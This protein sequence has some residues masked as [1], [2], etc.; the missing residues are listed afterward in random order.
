MSEPACLGG[1]PQ[2]SPALPMACPQLPPIESVQPAFE[3][4]MA[5]GYMTKGPELAAFEE[6]CQDYL[7]VEHCMGVSSCTSG[8]MMT[9]QAL[10]AT[11]K[12]LSRPRIA[13]PSFT[14]M[15]SLSA[16]RWS[17]FEPVFVDV[18]PTT[19]NLCLKDLERVLTEDRVAAVLAVHCFGNPVPEA[20]IEALC[21]TAEVK[22]MYDSAHG[23]GSLH[24]GRKVGSS[25]WCQVYS[26]TPTKMVVAGEGGIVA[27]NDPELAAHVRQSREYGNDGSY[28]SDF[29][30]INGRLSEIHAAI[31]RQSLKM[32]EGVVAFRNELACL[33]TGALKDIPGVGFQTIT[34]GSRTTYKDFVITIDESTFGCSRDAAAWALGQEGVPSRAYF[35]PPCHQHVA[36]RQFHQRPLPATE[37]LAAQTLA[38]PML[39]K[40][41]AEPL[42]QALSRIQGQAGSVK[43]RYDAEACSVQG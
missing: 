9:M 29:P 3:R 7:G 21:R 19:M 23:F 6:A 14:F 18:D 41:H 27:T 15:A 5:S 26:L 33:M 36:Y 34:E 32:L 22:L 42:A 12:G 13:V 35:S 11:P 16:M 1:S 37:V 28:G 17:G 20:D 43:E 30:G 2:F 8:L 39:D 38:L 40:A 25:G 31:G 10:K 24:K 4:I